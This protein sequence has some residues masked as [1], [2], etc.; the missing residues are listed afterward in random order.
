M[1]FAFNHANQPVDAASRLRLGGVAYKADLV[2]G[3]AV[4]AA[5][6]F[7]QPVELSSVGGSANEAVDVIKDARDAAPSAARVHTAE[8]PSLN[9]AQS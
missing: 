4:N 1:V 2:T 7:R 3:Q 8:S 5:S 9:C 6:Q